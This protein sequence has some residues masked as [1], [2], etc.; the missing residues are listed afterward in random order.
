[1]RPAD[2]RRPSAGPQVLKTDSIASIAVKY[3]ISVGQGTG[4]YLMSRLG[5]DLPTLSHPHCPAAPRPARLEP[6]LAVRPALPPHRALDPPRPVSP[7]DAR[8][9]AWRY[10]G[11]RR[12]KARERRWDEGRR[13]GG[14]GGGG[15]GPHALGCCGRGGTATNGG[16]RGGTGLRG[17][18][19]DFN[20]ERV[21]RVPRRLGRGRRRRAWRGSQGLD[22]GPGCGWLSDDAEPVRS[23]HNVLDVGGRA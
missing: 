23:C 22:A 20:P 1:M 2:W 17:F 3:G 12:S 11:T 9:G 15:R 14:K 21:E 16:E 10:R 6:P 5:A 19:C 18:V 8:A 7:P 4:N 13:R